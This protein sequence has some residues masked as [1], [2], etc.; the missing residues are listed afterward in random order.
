[1][2]DKITKNDGATVIIHNE[3]N[4]MNQLSNC[5]DTDHPAQNQYVSFHQPLSNAIYLKSS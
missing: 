3:S 2:V 4:K 5:W 1:M